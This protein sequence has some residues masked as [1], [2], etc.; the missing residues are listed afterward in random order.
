MRKQLTS[1]NRQLF[2]LKTCIIDICL[3]SNRNPKTYFLVRQM[4]VTL[5]ESETMFIGTV[6]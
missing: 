2:R 4:G 5:L 3:G 1:C 6:W